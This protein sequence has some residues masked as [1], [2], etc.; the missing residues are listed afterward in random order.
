[1]GEKSMMTV[2]ELQDYLHVCER[3]VFK[4]IKNK[5]IPCLKICG[6]WRFEKAKIDEWVARQYRETG[7]LPEYEDKPKILIVDDEPEL[8]EIL[9][10]D[11]LNYMPDADVETAP[12]GVQALMAVGK[13][14]P[15]VMIL[16]IQLPELNGIEVCRRL[17]E[18]PE[19]SDIFIVA[20]TGF[21]DKDYEEKVLAAGANE[22][23]EKPIRMEKVV[24]IIKQVALLDKNQNA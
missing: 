6:V 19:T 22:F 23:L 24:E 18:N 8:L 5:K 3:T 4:M 16:D 21:K 14:K 12:N 10:E 9:T 17:K 11:L 7:V 2:K 1:M 15:N 20:V 13:S